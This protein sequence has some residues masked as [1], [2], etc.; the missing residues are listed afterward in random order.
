MHNVK[1][2]NLLA[3]LGLT[4]LVGCTSGDRLSGKWF[5]DSAQ[6]VLVLNPDGSYTYDAY[7]MQTPYQLKGKYTYDMPTLTLKPDKLDIKN[8]VED[9]YVQRMN[10]GLMQPKVFKVN[11]KDDNFAVLDI[12][13][14]Q[15]SQLIRASSIPK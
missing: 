3:G 15:Q 6:T 9:F 1:L 7:Y 11:W 2:R 14:G 5:I 4:L 10:K 13:G 12:E 8:K